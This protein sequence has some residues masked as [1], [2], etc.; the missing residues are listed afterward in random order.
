[1][2]ARNQSRPRDKDTWAGLFAGYAL[3]PPPAGLRERVMH[4]A[5]RGPRLPMS[6]V[7]LRW[8]IAAMVLTFIWAA[9]QE[10]QTA[11]QMARL[12]QRSPHRGVEEAEPAPPHEDMHTGIAT[13]WLRP[14]IK[15]PLPPGYTSTRLDL[16]YS[17]LQPQWQGGFL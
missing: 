13:A 5:G 12:A 1:M 9:W 3:S 14:R 7:A 16:R 11:E 6:E 10:R 2:T 17:S 15:M 8:A 4:A